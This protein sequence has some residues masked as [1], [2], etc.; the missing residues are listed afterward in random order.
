MM[1]SQSV[2]VPI[3]RTRLF[4]RSQSSHECSLCICVHFFPTLFHMSSVTWLFHLVLGFPNA[5]HVLL[6]LHVTVFCRNFISTLHLLSC[7]LVHIKICVLYFIY[8]YPIMQHYF[9]FSLQ[10][11]MCYFFK[12]QTLVLSLHVF[13]CVYG[14]FAHMNADMHMYYVVFLAPSL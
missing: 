3:L 13:L 14:L 9:A 11:D 7:F 12:Y 1:T 6:P 5:F 10:P 2:D 8:I 4:H